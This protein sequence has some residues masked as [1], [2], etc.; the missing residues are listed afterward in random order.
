MKLYPRQSVCPYC[1]TVYRYADLRGL[2]WKKSG[3]CYHCK[4]KFVVSRKSF[5]I[6]AAEMLIIYTVMNIIAIG[7]VSSVSFL[8]LFI[9]NLIP[10]VAAVL[11]LPMYTELKKIDKKDKKSS[12]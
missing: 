1:K 10:A 12:E 6:L 7:V 4:K 3:V 5:L 8:S 2:V 11:L 9:M